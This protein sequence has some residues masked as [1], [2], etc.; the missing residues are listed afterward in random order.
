[1]VYIHY[2]HN[3][4]DEAQFMPIQNLTKWIKPDGGL[5]ASPVKS[6]YGW[7]DWNETSNYMRCDEKNSFKFKLKTDAKVLV[8]D[9]LKSLQR[10]IPD[11]KRSIYGYVEGITEDTKQ[12]YL[13]FEVLARMYDAILYE[14]SKCQ[15]LYWVLYGWDCDSLLVLNKDKIEVL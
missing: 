1:M 2:G 15:E 7:K 12:Y 11:G 10:L 6:S 8:I 4:Y 5:W 13:N 9:S 3:N 14:V